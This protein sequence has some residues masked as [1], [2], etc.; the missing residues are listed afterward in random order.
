MDQRPLN[1][2]RRTLSQLPP[3]APLDTS[4]NWSFETWLLTLLS[5]HLVRHIQPETNLNQ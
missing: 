1:L 5:G 4:V 3:D 2:E